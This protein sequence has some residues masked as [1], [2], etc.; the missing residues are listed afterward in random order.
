MVISE[1]GARRQLGY[2]YL[3]SNKREYNDV[4][5]KTPSKYR[6]LKNLKRTKKYALA[7]HICRTWYKGQYTMMAK[8][9]NIVEFHY[10]MT[11]FNDLKH[12][13]MNP[14]QSGSSVLARLRIERSVFQHWLGTLCCV[15]G[16]D[17]LAVPLSQCHSPPKLGNDKFNV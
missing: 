14:T 13:L 1:Q 3:M 9:I 4:L 12:L 16:Q 5:T 8:P 7:Y 10:S 6:K 11:H 15:L 17:T 2:N